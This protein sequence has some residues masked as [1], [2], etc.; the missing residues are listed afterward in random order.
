MIDYSETTF[1]HDCLTGFRS[2]EDLPRFIEEWQTSDS[3][4]AL[5]EC[6]GLT[7][8]QYKKFI[9]DEYY[10]LDIL[11]SKGYEN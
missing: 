10:L 2:F 5:H 6:L 1:I 7:T 9:K 3:G 4:Y 11:R 8:K